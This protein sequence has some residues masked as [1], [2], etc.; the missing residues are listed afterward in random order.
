MTFSCVMDLLKYPLDNQTCS[1]Q[2]ASCKKLFSD[3]ITVIDL[4]VLPLIRCIY[5]RGYSLYMGRKTIAYERES[6]KCF[7]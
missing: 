1:I 3:N 6:C 2:F 7:V 4:I 5:D